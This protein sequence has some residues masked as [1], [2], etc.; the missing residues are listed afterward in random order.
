[1]PPGPSSGW[2][3]DKGAFTTAEVTPRLDWGS[4]FAIDCWWSVPVADSFTLSDP[5][6]WWLE[7]CWAAPE[8]H[9]DGFVA[10]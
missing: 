1:M 7:G 9:E 8:G 3:F 4:P 2:A 5:R 10:A 6:Y